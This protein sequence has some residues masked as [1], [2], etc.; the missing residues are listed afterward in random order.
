MRNLYPTEEQ[1]QKAFVDW[2]LLHPLLKRCVICIGNEG[3]R[4]PRQGYAMKRKGMRK[5]AS[6]LLIAYP[7]KTHAGLWVEMKAI[8]PR[9]GKYRKPT[10]EQIEFI[11]DMK[12]L[13]YDGCVA[14][15]ADDAINITKN[16]LIP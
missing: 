12:E 10:K 5:G 8:D 6:D 3:K 14:N 11:N 1:E 15:G 4:S 9:T 7:T 2:C 13:G 16:Y